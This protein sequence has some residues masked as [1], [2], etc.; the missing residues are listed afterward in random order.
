MQDRLRQITLIVLSVLQLAANAASGAG[1]LFSNGV[2]V[3]EISD[4]F[5]T[6]F[7]PAGYTFAVWGPIYL[8]ITLYA[9]YQA[10]PGQAYRS[11]H[12]RVG[13]WAVSAAAANTLWTPV[14]TSAGLYGTEAFQPG[15]VVLSLVIIVWMLVSLARIFVILRNMNADLTTA[16]RWLV[17][18]PFYGYF[19]WVNVA[20]VANA[21]TTLISLGWAGTQNGAL[22]SAVIILTATLITAALVL[23]SRRSPGTIAFVAVLVWAFVG[24]YMGNNAQSG[25]VGGAAVAAVVVLVGV[26][27]FRFFSDGGQSSQARPAAA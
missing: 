16:D 17:Q 19:A 24:V 26:A 5:R 6:F 10:L 4:S 27:I 7:T 1:L 25:L 3:G 9:L 11:V 23:Y 12:R 21:T 13:W 8:G 18:V 15:I 22:W 14:F 2:T 20:T